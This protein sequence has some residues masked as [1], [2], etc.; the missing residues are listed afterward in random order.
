MSMSDGLEIYGA[1][2]MTL[3]ILAG[4]IKYLLS[5]YITP[6]MNE[7]EKIKSEQNGIKD[8]EKDQQ[9]ELNEIKKKLVDEVKDISKG[10]FDFRLKYETSMSEIKLLLVEKY[11]SKQEI[12]KEIEDIL[13]KIEHIRE[14]HY[15]M[16]SIRKY[17]ESLKDN[18]RDE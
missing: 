6:L 9:I 7:I 15:E 2:L 5:N 1:A 17:I 14:T 3:T 16:K 10:N 11:F 12:E 4:S 18:K 13:K 8:L